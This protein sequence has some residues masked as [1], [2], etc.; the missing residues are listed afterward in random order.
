MIDPSTVNFDT[1]NTAHLPPTPS[2]KKSLIMPLLL[3]VFGISA[4]GYCYYQ[5]TQNPNSMKNGK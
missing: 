1:L 2:N 4:F 5:L 3:V